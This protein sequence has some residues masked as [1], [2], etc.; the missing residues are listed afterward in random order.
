LSHNQK[1]HTEKQ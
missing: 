1:M